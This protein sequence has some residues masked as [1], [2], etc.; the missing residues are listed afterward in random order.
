[1]IV[2]IPTLKTKNSIIN[3]N[4]ISSKD[5]I[6]FLSNDD[7]KKSAIADLNVEEMVMCNFL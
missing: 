5:E 7:K 6:L 4:R 2:Q 1:M 3:Q